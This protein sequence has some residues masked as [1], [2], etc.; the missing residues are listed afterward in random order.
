VALAE[1]ARFAGLP[2]AHVA[3]SALRASGFDAV[4]LDQE[5]AQNLWREP[6]GKG[7]IRLCVPEGDE[8]AARALLRG[9]RED[10]AADA[11]DLAPP[12][13]DRGRPGFLRLAAIALVLLAI[14]AFALL[15]RL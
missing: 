15:G 2:E 14:L 13:A 4:V 6:Y 3:C 9:L 5:P 7:G 1:V 12:P 8:A 10:G 11:P